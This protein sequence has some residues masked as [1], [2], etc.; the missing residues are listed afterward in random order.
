M[1]NTMSLRAVALNVLRWIVLLPL[2]LAGALLAMFLCLK[3]NQFSFGAMGVADGR[4]FTVVSAGVV[5]GAA[6][7][8]LGTLIAPSGGRWIPWLLAVLC[9][10]YLG[11]GIVPLA[12]AGRWLDLVT[13]AALAVSGLATAWVLTH[14]AGASDVRESEGAPLNRADRD[15]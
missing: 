7:V 14:V 1:S 9:V 8:Y 2:A 4:Y 13:S 15:A 6:F 10:L 5:T 3:L 11:M 12:R